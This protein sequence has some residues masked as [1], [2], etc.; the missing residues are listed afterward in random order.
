MQLGISSFTYTWAV[1][2]PG[3]PPAQPL[4][5][6]GLRHKAKLLGVSTI[7][8]ADNLPL[9]TLPADSVNQLERSARQSRIHLQVGTRGIAP[10][11][12]ITYLALAQRLGSPIL[13]VVIDT[14]DHHPA[15]P[16]IIAILREVESAFRAA[17]VTLTIENH[18]RFTCHEFRQL[19]ETLG[20]WTG[21]C[22][23]TVNSFGALESPQT[24]IDTLAPITVNL[25]IKDFTIQRLG[26]Q[27]G[28]IIEG[29]PAGQGR[30]DIPALLASVQSQGHCGSAILELWTPPEAL[31]GDTL[32]LEERWARESIGYLRTLI[33]D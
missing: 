13:R 23:D 26:H 15:I 27:M 1:G 14:A 22:L 17:D 18:D 25:H 19:V 30:L 31:I 11:H 29:R 10:A 12:L 28:F 9:H 5:V 2:V 3:Y 8:F 33:P 21:I 16:E 20:D 24:V 32:A 6:F 4:D 7:Q